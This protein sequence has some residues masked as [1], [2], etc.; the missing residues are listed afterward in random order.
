MGSARALL[1]NA[2][3]ARL[4]ASG[5]SPT[6]S[7]ADVCRTGGGAD[8]RRATGTVRVS[9][10]RVLGSGCLTV[11]AS[12]GISRWL[13]LPGPLRSPRNILSRSRLLFFRDGVRCAVLFE[14][15]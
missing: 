15:P 1:R 14:R 13:G 12:A 8:N 5:F 3:F 4:I 10:D 7:A 11:G 9:A 2:L 6:L